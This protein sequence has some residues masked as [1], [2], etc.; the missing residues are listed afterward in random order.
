MNEKITN[1]LRFS[2]ILR[3]DPNFN[4]NTE[5]RLAVFE[6]LDNAAKFIEANDIK[7]SPDDQKLANNK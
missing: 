4:H 2:S 1:F 7:L 3:N 5:V 6:A